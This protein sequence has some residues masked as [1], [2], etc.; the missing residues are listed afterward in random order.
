MPPPSKIDLLPEEVRRELDER[1]VA[2]GF[3]GYV[4]LS[5]WLA[6]RGYEI[7]KSTL[8]MHGKKMERRLSAVRASTQAAA[9]FEEAARDDTDARSAAIFAQV[10]SGLFDALVDFAE[11][12]DE[13][14]P[15]KRAAIYARIGKDFAAAASGSR[16]GKKF[17]REVREQIAAALAAMKKEGFD[18]GTLEEAERRISIYLPANNR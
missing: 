14:D 9:L 3:G 5:E 6:E 7:G 12:E 11:A 4:A 15:V 10:Q 8:G 1:I 16:A 18:A 13:T 2:A 17:A